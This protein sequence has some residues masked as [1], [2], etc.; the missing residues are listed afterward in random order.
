MKGQVL[1]PLEGPLG[2]RAV[3]LEPLRELS[4]RRFGGLAPGVGDETDDRWLDGEPAVCVE[5]LD[6]RELTAGR[7]D[8]AL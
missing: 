1:D 6:R 4:E 7:P 3:D 8:G 2:S 5:L